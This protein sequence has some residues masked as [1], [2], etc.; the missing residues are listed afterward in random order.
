MGEKETWNA[1]S[2]CFRWWLMGRCFENRTECWNIDARQL[3][4]ICGIWDNTVE[5]SHG[6]HLRN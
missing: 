2:G 4:S 6:C 3:A 1:K 5:V